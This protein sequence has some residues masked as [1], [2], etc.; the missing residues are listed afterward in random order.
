MLSPGGSQN[1]VT[2]TNSSEQP[3]TEDLETLLS[4]ASSSTYDNF[5]FTAGTYQINEVLVLG[6]PMILQGVG[7]S[8]NLEFTFSTTY[9]FGGGDIGLINLRSSHITLENFAISFGQPSVD[10]SPNDGGGGGAII[11][12][13]DE[14]GYQNALVDIKITGLTVHGVQDTTD[15]DGTYDD[16]INPHGYVTTPTLQ[17]GPFD[18]GTIENNIIYAGMV[19]VSWGPWTI[20][21]N[22]IVGSVQGTI[23]FAAFSVNGGHDVTIGNN[24]VTDP[25]PPADGELERLMTLNSGGYDINV[26]GN[27]VSQ[28][29]G[30]LTAYGGPFNNPEEILPETYGTMFEGNTN[31]VSISST[32]GTYNRTVIAIP[33]SEMFGEPTT[34]TTGLVL[35]ILD[36]S[37]AGTSIPVTQVL[38]GSSSGAVSA[39]PPSGG[40]STNYFLLASSLPQDPSGAFDFAI[41]ASY[42]GFTVSGNTID[43]SNTVSTAV[44]LTSYMNN[45]QVI[46]NTFIGDQTHTPGYYSQAIRVSQ[47]GAG[48]GSSNPLG[49]FDGEQYNVSFT[50]MFD[51]GISG[52]TIINSIGGIHIYEF[53]FP[54]VPTTYGRTY[55][56]VSL[57]NN[58]FLYSYQNLGLIHIGDGNLDAS[59]GGP[60]PNSYSAIISGTNTI[61]PDPNATNFVDPNEFRVTASG[62]TV[63]WAG[64]SPPGSDVQVDAADVNGTLYDG[65][66]YQTP[67]LLTTGNSQ[68]VNI[69]SYYDAV[70]ITADNATSAGAL[71]SSGDSISAT[72][73][74]QPG[75]WASTLSDVWAAGGQGFLLGP[76]GSDDVVQFKGQTITL[77]QG[78]WTDLLLLA[79]AA[80]STQSTTITV[81]Y[82]SGASVTSGQIFSDFV[83]GDGPPTMIARQAVAATLP[84][85]NT[86]RE[87]HRGMGTRS[88]PAPRATR[89]SPA[90]SRGATSGCLP[91]TPSGTLPTTTRRTVRPGPNPRSTLAPPATQQSRASP[92][93][94]RPRCL[95]ST[96][97]GTSRTT[98]RA[99]LRGTCHP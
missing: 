92:R 37:N 56:V 53:T 36:G 72:T 34:P 95:L 39:T 51:I 38:Y 57:T 84:Y 61:I 16:T 76:A 35:D 42:N 52:N 15:A 18:S 55:T 29:V 3:V 73:L 71:D 83:T 44:V 45:V 22:T 14:G 48:Q 30:D 82:T 70:G 47:Y 33:S 7:G 99:R 4:Q 60:P 75:N 78:Q 66:S 43:T 23:S 98:R 54:S 12:A 5:E 85:Y 90:S 17:M 6:A 96:L 2:Y 65:E 28:N 81:N 88:T 31:A 41:A 62:N 97:A 79:L 86:G 64:V 21:G 25:N 80:G 11:D 9:Q 68:P 8:S 1:M 26:T 94:P 13:F 89:R 58:T 87:G 91:S 19:T 10:L 74:E 77:P 46:G 20:T 50:V 93:G 69:S 63:E 32:T 24:T 40:A 27:S 59:S 67:A 49:S